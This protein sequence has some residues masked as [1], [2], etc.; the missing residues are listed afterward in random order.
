[1]SL[2]SLKQIAIY[3]LCCVGILGTEMWR[4]IRSGAVCRNGGFVTV[5][6]ITIVCLSIKTLY[7]LNCKVCW[8]GV[9]CVMFC[10]VLRPEDYIDTKSPVPP[11]LQQP[12]C[13]KVLDLPYSIHAFQHLRVSEQMDMCCFIS[14]SIWKRNS[15]VLGATVS[16]G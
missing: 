7:L 10:S 12:D 5:G 15:K 3:L 13:T 9:Y 16:Q 4:G 2:S 1:M 14:S 8:S 11:D 6:E